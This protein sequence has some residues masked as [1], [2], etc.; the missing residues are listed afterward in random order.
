MA[1]TNLTPFPGSARAACWIMFVLFALAGAVWLAPRASAKAERWMGTPPVKTETVSLKRPVL[2][3]K[4]NSPARRTNALIPSAVPSAVPSPA[5]VETVDAG[6]RFTMLGVLCEYPATEGDVVLRLRTS[7]DGEDWSAWLEAPLERPAGAAEAAGDATAPR[8]FTEAIWTGHGRYVQISARAAAGDAPVSLGGVRLVTLDTD[9][10]QSLQEQALAAVR[11]V[12]ATIAGVGLAAPAGASIAEP[13]LVTRS[14]WGA[15]ESLRDGEPAYAPVKMAFVHHTAGGNTYSQADAPALV[16]GIYTYHVKSLGWSDIGYNFLIDRFGKTYVGR[17][18]GPRKG[19][20]GAQVY[21]FNTGSTGV[22]VMGTYTDEAPPAATITALQKLLAWKLE[23]HGL[24][25]LGKATMTCGATAKFTVGQ[26]V[27]LPVISGHRDANF[28]A[29]PGDAFSAKLPAVRKAVGKLFP[30]P[31][32]TQLTLSAA[33]LSPNGDGKLDELKVSSAISETSRWVVQVVSSNGETVR[34]Y[35]GEGD[36][37]KVVWDGRNQAGERVKDGVYT[38]R[39][40]AT[41]TYGAVATKTQPVTIDTVAPRVAQGVLQRATFSPNGDGWKD[42]TRLTYRPDE[43]CS[44]RHSIVDANGV[45]RR[46][47]S[48]WTKVT[49]TAARTVTWAGKIDKDGGQADAPDGNYRIRVE[50]R[51][52][53]GNTRMRGYPVRVDRTVGF[54]AA[55]PTTISP[56][57]DGVQDAARLTFRLSRSATVVVAVAKDGVVVRSLRAGS[58]AAGARGVVWDGR[59]STG[60]RA[61]NGKYTFTVTAKS[62]VG[63][64]DVRK[65]VAADRYKPRL[66]SSN[67]TVITLGQTAKA[68]VRVDDPHSADVQRW[69]VVTN[70]KGK[71]FGKLTLGWLKTSE[72]ATA[73]WRP[74]SRGTYIFTF[75]ARDRGGNRE[76]APVRTTITVR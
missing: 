37:L 73:T 49:T 62:V 44:L 70:A 38:V 45:T 61:A 43:A 52:S 9:G 17:Y 42:S 59:T 40:T 63:S 76:Y 58:L 13:S 29:C 26:R 69:C 15:N 14:Q 50:L 39:V 55:T 18:G 46:R 5:S 22:S 66:R 33:T 35:S 53:T 57:G 64:S 2:V 68:T 20:I 1:R 8:S 48:A 56:N 41:S 34:R 6:H 51:D 60:A 24:N 72:A 74:V 71:Q 19:V 54:A 32:I 16:R 67:S 21:G 28:T 75:T 23:L 11:H 30:P 65:P 3:V 10:G 27:T 7:I 25:P 12:A 36:A 4:K 31:E 47:L